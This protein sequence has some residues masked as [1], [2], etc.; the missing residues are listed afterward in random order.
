MMHDKSESQ[1]DHIL[2]DSIRMKA[3]VKPTGTGRRFTVAKDWGWGSKE[4]WEIAD[5]IAKGFGVFS[6]VIKML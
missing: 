3:Q 2:Y 4:G 5:I 1:K 6:E